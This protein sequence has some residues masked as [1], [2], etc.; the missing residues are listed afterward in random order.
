MTRPFLR[1][2]LALASAGLLSGNALAGQ[3]ITEG[4][5]S[6][7]EDVH[8]WVTEGGEGDV[9]IEKIV[10]EGED[11]EEVKVIVMKKSIEHDCDHHK[12]HD[13]EHEHDEEHEV[14]VEVKV[15]KKEKIEE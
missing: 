7:E 8:V 5:G 12:D 15:K 14:E 6:S 13:C 10:T 2:A 1:N 9:H 11:G 3:V 4:E